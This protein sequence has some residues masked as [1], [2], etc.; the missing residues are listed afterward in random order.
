MRRL[1]SLQP[2]QRLPIDLA[3][4]HGR[5][6]VLGQILARGRVVVNTQAHLAGTAAHQYVGKHEVG[7]DVTASMVGG[8]LG[9][10]GGAEAESGQNGTA[11]LVHGYYPRSM[12]V[13]TTCWKDAVLIVVGWRPLKYRDEGDRLHVYR[14]PAL[15][16]KL[17]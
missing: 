5:L 4:L 7:D 1:L 12:T 8:L 15:I 17:S 11:K 14:G 6:A 3:R 9:A 16:T 2:V 13:L 10:G